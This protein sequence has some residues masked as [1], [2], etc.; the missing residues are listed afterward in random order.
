MKHVMLAVVVVVAVVLLTA[1]VLGN[2]N[3]SLGINILGS[4]LVDAN[5]TAKACGATINNVIAN[6]DGARNIACFLTH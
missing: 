2:G 5:N 3:I 1:A 4:R 6:G